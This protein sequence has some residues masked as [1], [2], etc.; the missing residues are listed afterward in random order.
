MPGAWL[1]RRVS[2][3]G[4]GEVRSLQKRRLEARSAALGPTGSLAGVNRGREGG[5]EGGEAVPEPGRL[6]G[7]NGRR[8]S[9][10]VQEAGGEP[11][12]GPGTLGAGAWNLE[13][14]SAQPLE[15]SPRSLDAKGRGPHGEGRAGEDPGPGGP[16]R[17]QG[18]AVPGSRL[19]LPPSRQE[20]AEEPQGQHP[21]TRRRQGPEGSQAGRGR[22]RSRMT[23]SSHAAMHRGTDRR[24][25]SPRGWVSPP[26]PAPGPLPRS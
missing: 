14:S 21:H 7:A 17:L 25:Q 15:E 19:R 8:A 12:G 5:D 3:P 20:E 4:T 23:V 6:A 2:V 16:R 18:R 11:L 10:R 26:P 24:R 13:G 9:G 22:P 1:R